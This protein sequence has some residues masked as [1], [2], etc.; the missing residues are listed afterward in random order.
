VEKIEK[1]IEIE[2][3]A[4]IV[5]KT[6]TGISSY[7][8]WNPVVSHAA[9]YGPVASGTGIKTLVGKWDFEFTIIKVH[10]PREFELRGS[11]VGINL[12]LLFNIDFRDG[13]SLVRA[14]VHVG[15]WINTLFKKRVEAGVEDSLE[16]FL[17][18]LKNRASGGGSYEIKRE[19]NKK[20]ETRS[21]NISMPT[22]FNL[23]Y[24]TRA[25]KF[26]RGGLRL[27]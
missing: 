13:K 7:R 4:D 14:N 23:I 24:K 18:S 8:S 12:K 22:P 11:S 10:A 1:S 2:K 3:D 16:I 19:E 25:K 20:D 26:R 21:G 27:K 17:N 5:W 6:L 9:I 15:G